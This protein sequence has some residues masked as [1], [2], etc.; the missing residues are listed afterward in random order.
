[1]QSSPSLSAPK[2]PAEAVGRAVDEIRAGRIAIIVN[3]DDPASEGDLCMA[4]SQASAQ[5]VNFMLNRGRGLVCLPL[6]ED[7]MRKLGLDMMVR[8]GDAEGRL[9]MG[10]SIEAS[11]GVTT[12]ISAADRATTIRAAVAE[13]ARPDHLRSPG[14]V[15]PVRVRRG[16]V[17]RNPGRAE[18]AVDLARLAG[19]P[20]AA[21][22]C[23][24]LREDGGMAT[25]AD[26]HALAGAEGLALVSVSDLLRYRLQHETLVRRAGEAKLPTRNAGTFRAIVY[27]NEIDGI[28]HMAIVK[29]DVAS[30]EPVLVRLHSECLT[31]DAFHSLRCDCGEQLDGAMERIEREGRGVILYLRQEGRGIGLKNKIRAYGLQDREGLDT[32]EAN[33]QLGFAADQ[34]DYG[35]G[36]QILVELG[37]RRLRLLTNNPRKQS[38]IEALGLEIVERVPLEI[39]PNEKN[40][41]YLRTKREK[42]GHEL[43][44]GEED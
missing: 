13:G 17:L 43:R 23:Q 18:A 42:L 40:L 32:V 8:E 27:E 28:D 15:F 35:V 34:R 38:A 24:V 12:G 25:L 21:V 22:T 41:E 44:F 29:G 3:D 14:H 36:G 11:E 37:V 31:G 30:G 10:V 1:V 39:T 2:D 26:L 6:T 16:G 5:A 4:A 19:L 9:P 7:R 33:V 20:P